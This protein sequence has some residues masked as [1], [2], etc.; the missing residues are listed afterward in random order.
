MI[1]QWLALI[2]VFGVVLPAC[3]QVASPGTGQNFFA[4]Q[5]ENGFVGRVDGTDAFV[6]ILIGDSIAVAYVCNGNAE[7]SEWFKGSVVDPAA[8]TLNNREGAQ[9]V[10]QLQNGIFRGQVTMRDGRSFSF[11]AEPGVA[12]SAGI[13]RVMGTDAATDSVD[14][15]WVRISETEERGAL[16]VGSSFRTAT[17]LPQSNATVGGRSYPVFRFQIRRLLPP[18]I[19]PFVPIPYPN[20]PPPA[21]T[22]KSGG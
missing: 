12:E 21:D 15:G 6:S 1:K 3:K 18:G 9:I 11:E 5:G 7:I 14:A 16:R 4:L 8:V 2:L 10:G 17:A 19:A 13:Y 20:L 22:T